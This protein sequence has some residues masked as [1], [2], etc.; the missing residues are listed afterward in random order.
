LL[1]EPIRFGVRHVGELATERVPQVAGAVGLERREELG[2][3]FVAKRF[4]MHLDV[5]KAHVRE[6]E[7]ELLGNASIRGM[8]DQPADLGGTVVRVTDLE[9]G[10]LEVLVERRRVAL[11]VDDV[12]VDVRSIAPSELR[13]DH[14]RSDYAA[15][16][17][18]D[19]HEDV[20]AFARLLDLSR[21]ALLR[22]VDD[23]PDVL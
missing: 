21:E 16:L 6:K 20:V 4:A 23:R 8:Q 5:E 1:R 19:E 10:L 9:N 3:N 13:D 17:A 14:R 2:E 15:L 12:D 7:T 18:I 22:V 11:L